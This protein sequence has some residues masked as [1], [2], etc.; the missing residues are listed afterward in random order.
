[1]LLQ[2][3]AFR[4]ETVLSLFRRLPGRLFLRHPL[5]QRGHL[6]GGTPILLIRLSQL[7]ARPFQFG[8][9]MEE[10]LGRF[11]CRHLFRLPLDRHLG[12]WLLRRSSFRLKAALGLSRLIGGLGQRLLGRLVG[13]FFLRHPLLQ[14]SDLFAS[15]PV[16]LVRRLQ[17]LSNS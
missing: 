14:G 7:A 13:R 11:I 4:L 15:S 12:Q 16:L 1:M 17:F 5:L 8:F 6:F 3:G 10:V 2:R 9:Q